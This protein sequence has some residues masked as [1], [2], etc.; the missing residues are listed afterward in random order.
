[1]LVFEERGK[2]EYPEKNLSEQGRKPTTNSTHIWRRHGDLNPG[3]IGGRRVLSSLRHHL[4][5]FPYIDNVFTSTGNIWSIPTTGVI[6][7]PWKL[8][9]W[10]K[11][12]AFLREEKR[13]KHTQW[14]YLVGEPCGDTRSG[15][16]TALRGPAHRP[17]RNAQMK[18]MVRSYLWWPGLDTDIEDKVKSSKV[19]QLHRAAPLHPWEWPEKS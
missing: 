7:S 15:S 1:M 5:P 8:R 4:L 2:P 11:P 3:H 9:C 16:E 19:C 14:L 13:I 17:P 18:N 12:G 10:Q 6:I